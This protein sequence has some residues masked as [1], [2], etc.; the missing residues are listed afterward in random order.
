VIAVPV[1][2]ILLY[3]CKIRV[4][5]KETLSI[6]KKQPRPKFRPIDLNQDKII[7]SQDQNEVKVVLLEISNGNI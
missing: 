4:A 7:R 1:E 6:I 2:E 3:H 5:L